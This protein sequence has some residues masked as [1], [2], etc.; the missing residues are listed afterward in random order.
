MMYCSHTCMR[1]SNDCGFRTK[2][3]FCELSPDVYYSDKTE[4]KCKV[5]YLHI[6][7]I[8]KTDIKL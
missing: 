3:G 7:S 1:F 4:D 8:T 6:D 2:D 5:S